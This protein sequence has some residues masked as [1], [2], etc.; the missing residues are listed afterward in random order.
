MKPKPLLLALL[1][2]GLLAA[3]LTLPNDSQGQ[4]APA[5]GDRTTEALLMEIGAQQAAIQRN[6]AAMD[7][8]LA[9]MSENIRL[10]RIYVS[11]GGGKAK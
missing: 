3:G 8:K 5:T 9:A 4:A 2:A 7:A 10:A 1:G 11:R 6:Q